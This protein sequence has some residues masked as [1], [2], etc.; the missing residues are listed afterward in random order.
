MNK[1]YFVCRHAGAIDWAKQQGIEVD[2][3]IP[4]LDINDLRRN[5]IVM[6][7]LPVHLAA[8]VC[9][10]GAKY[11]HLTLTIPEHLRGKELTAKE[12]DECGAQLR[13]Y[14]VNQSD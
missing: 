6:G 11:F 12:M 4:H 14:E 8:E 5:D 13:S 7:T 3:Q 9:A 2:A 10:I 1:R